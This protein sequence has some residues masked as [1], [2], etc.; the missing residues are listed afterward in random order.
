MRRG[1]FLRR[2]QVDE[3]G[4]EHQHELR[5]E[6]SVQPH[7]DRQ[8]AAHPGGDARGLILRADVG[9]QRA[10]NSPAV[11]GKRRQQIESRQ[12][13]VAVSQPSQ[14]VRIGRLQQIGQA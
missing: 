10:Q 1:A 12:Q 11:H 3:E 13:Q 8:H 5:R 2:A 9:K 4:E 6:Q 14:G 7:A